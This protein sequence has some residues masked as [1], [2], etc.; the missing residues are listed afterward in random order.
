MILTLDFGST[1]TKAG[2]W[3]NE[4]L[5]ALA[6]CEL[7]TVHRHP[8]W[9]EQDPSSWWT[10]LVIA[11][12]EV[13]AKAPE[14][15]RS[16]D[17]IGAT[18]ARQSFALAAGS[19]EPVGPGI[20]WSDRRAVAEI[21][22]VVERAGESTDIRAR[23]GVPLDASCVAAKL[24]WLEVNEPSRL[25]ASDW[26]LSPRDLM[27]WRLT[28]EVVTDMTMASRSGLHDE[29]GRVI[30]ELAGRALGLLPPLVPSDTVAG[31]LRAVP[32]AELG[33]RPGIPV[34]VGAGD[35]ACEVLGS[36]ALPDGP[37]VSWGT[38]AN[39]S[40]PVTQRPKLVDVGAVVST[41][42]LGG[43]LL[44]AGLSSAGS[45]IDWLARISGSS[46]SSLVEM[47]N[48]SP[49]GARG[50]VAV[51]WLDGARAPWWNDC[52][53]AGFVGLSFAHGPGDLARAAIESIVFDIVACLKSIGGLRDQD[54]PVRA[55]NLC[56]A[57]SANALWVNIL[58]AA[59][60]L[61]AIQRESGEA[62]SAGAAM[63]AARS[64]GMELSIDTL[65]PV[66]SEIVPDPESMEI[67]QDLY[68]RTRTAAQ[69]LIDLALS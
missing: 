49:P 21:E 30:A 29:S 69:I 7:R 32:A 68:E 57:G 48:L 3:H 44:E 67:Y 38:T 23:T 65:N 36:G 8:G 4:G 9:A 66:K 61:N 27:T 51:P 15:F 10:S 58:T 47:A 62:A 18:G 53:R 2:L 40:L 31:Q 46:V 33:L 17:V 11:C 59:T 35:R 45:F 41:G 20:L 42:A 54:R 13:R 26:L 43:W 60:G 24:L 6:H 5:V 63:L 22:R 56:G 28:G 34:T 55:M 14:A 64:V 16:V 52:A 1:A 12:A 19:G 25:S 39:I 37:M 50:V